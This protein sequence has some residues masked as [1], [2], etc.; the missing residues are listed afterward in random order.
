[1]S[2]PVLS[3]DEITQK[4]LPTINQWCLC[5]GLLMY[6]P[7]FQSSPNSA[8]VAPITIYPTIIPLSAFKEAV[9]VQ[10]IYNELYVKVI[11]DT[12]W[13]EIETEK[14]SRYDLTF[15]GRLWDMYLKAKKIGIIQKLELGIFRNDF[16]LDK[17]EQQQIKQVEF[18]TVSV[19]FGGL[20]SKVSH[21]H[22]YLYKHELYGS[23]FEGCEIPISESSKLLADGLS[24]GVRAYEKQNQ[25]L[26]GQTVVAFIVQD[27]ERNVFD[28]R[29]L[30]YNLWE[31]H[32]IKSIRMTIH[33][34]HKLTAKND[35]GGKLIYKPTNEEI[36]VVYFRSGYS[37]QDF[38]SEQDWENRLFLETSL[39]IKAPSL[40]TQLS[41]TKK[42]QQLLTE[43]ETLS[44]FIDTEKIKKITPTFVKIYPLDDSELG[45]LARKLAFESPENY[46]LKPQ[47]EGGGNNIYKEDIPKFL[48]SMNKSEWNA[49][50][51]MELI[52][53][54]PTEKNVILRDNKLY[55]ESILSELGIFGVVL[56][57]NDRILYNEYSGWL[58]RSKFSSSNEGGVAAGFGCVDSVA[59]LRY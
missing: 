10:T 11:Q 57:D 27:G 39:A 54:E 48:N 34:I 55:R 52:N 30:E 29:I 1:M 45:Q 51:L 41:G 15:T 14:L 31:K 20:S 23:N 4:L 12:E 43:H 46:V 58:L 53:P 9:S 32:S 36:S 38:K 56:F 8:T 49:Y 24:Q 50:I 35:L 3:D 22:S 2:Y 5:N 33:E 47:R 25:P 59:L 28:Q 44:K 37:P 40:K 18:N 16:L 19:S 42:I 13:L 21:L 26:N 6:P 17:G 7:A